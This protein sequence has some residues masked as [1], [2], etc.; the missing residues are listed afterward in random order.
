MSDRTDYCLQGEPEQPHGDD[1]AEENGNE[2]WAVA[3]SRLNREDAKRFDLVRIS[4]SK[5]REILNE[6]LQ[7]ANEKKDESM[8]KKWKVTIKGRTIILRDVLEKITVWVSR[9]MKIGDTIVQYDPACAALPWAA[10]RLILQAAVNDVET[11]GFILQSLETIANMVAYFSVFELRYLGSRVPRTIVAKKLDD[12]LIA[13]YTCILDYLCEVLRRFSQNSAVRFLK[14]VGS[15]VADL[16]AKF[17]PA[18]TARQRVLTWSRAADAERQ[19]EIQ[20]MLSGLQD[21]TAA[22]FESLSAAMKQMEEPIIRV[23]VRL[24][25]IQDHL[26]RLTR[27]RILKSISTI[28]YTTHHKSIRKDRLEGSGCWLLERPEYK[29]WR[30]DSCSS[31][32][33]LHGIPGSG[34]TKLASL[35][36]DKA[37]ECDNL[38]YFYCMR[39]PAEPD[40]GRGEK[41]LASL[42]RQLAGGSPDRPILPPVVAQYEDAIQEMVEFED[43][44]WTTD[45]SSRILLELMGEYPSATLVIDALDEV[46]QEDRQELLDILSSL[47]RDSPNLLKV[48]VSSRDNY[49]IALH[50]DGLPNVYIDAEDNAGDI[51]AFI[52]DR[53]EKARFL[54]GRASEELKDL[55]AKT[56]RGGARGMFRW[57]DLQIQSLRPLKV[58]ADIEARLG[59][60]PATLEGSYWQIFQDILASGAHAAELAIFTFQWLLYAQAS[61]PIEAFAYIASSALQS[62][63]DTATKSGDFTAIEITDVCCNLMVSRGGSFYF[64]HLS[65]REFFEGLPK[66]DVH[67]FEEQTCHSCIAEACL[68]HLLR[69]LTKTEESLLRREAL[70]A[71]YIDRFDATNMVVQSLLYATHC[72]VYHVNDS[73]ELRTKPALASPIRA[74]LL[75][76]FSST[77][78]AEFVVWCRWVKAGR[79]VVWH[80]QVSGSDAAPNMGTMVSFAGL[81]FRIPDQIL[82]ATKPPHNPIWLACLENWV[83][84]VEYLM[85]AKR[86]NEPDDRRQLSSLGPFR[87]MSPVDYALETENEPLLRVMFRFS[88]P[89]KPT[90]N[91][92]L[93][94]LARAAGDG[95]LDIV[96]LLLEQTHGGVGGEI[97]AL[98]EATRHDYDDIVKALIRHNDTLLKLGGG[99]ALNIAC[100]YGSEKI[101]AL[102]LDRGFTVTHDTLSLAVSG[103]HFSIVKYL[104]QRGIPNPSAALSKALT[105]SVSENHQNITAWLEGHFVD[106]EDIAVVRAVKLGATLAAT[107]LIK[108]GYDVQG[109]YLERKRTALHY[110]AEQGFKDVVSTLLEAGSP[111]D[112]HDIDGNTALHLAAARGHDNCVRLLLDRGADVLAENLA[113]EL[114]LD[115]AENKGR[116]STEKIIRDDMEKLM[117]YLQRAKERRLRKSHQED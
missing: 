83:E 17:A 105:L 85:A 82:D 107:R 46:N 72:W 30:D 10:V 93:P 102:L 68:G 5:P 1:D 14:G 92:L 64:S 37:G 59:V 52:D 7:A 90:G 78:S 25:G 28:P 3:L 6:V 26:D 60:L 96:R 22:G 54:H 69:N 49:D 70:N 99:R 4:A 2:R 48:F 36:I 84:L 58:A 108:A 16:E 32:L 27:G 112:L 66:R 40:R 106:K 44:A 47:M 109:T 103:G 35:V 65:V 62:S 21:K 117:K 86:G 97:L 116:T 13:L 67:R 101:V 100:R 75:D 89:L 98:N 53:I 39:N 20:Q 115:L 18:E 77:V 50:L 19:A 55:I 45:E 91:S 80:A 11:F 57:V 33:W 88:D 12:S 24:T 94:P 95:Y 76:N 51:S 8:R 111:I 74:F 38:A 73:G 114:P 110:A 63:T 29:A 79:P 34:K 87:I 113:G 81:Q 9:L 31:V 104:V 56:L 42:V 23:N 43:H 15:P 41:V 71:G 61:L